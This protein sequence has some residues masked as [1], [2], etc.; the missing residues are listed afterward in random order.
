MKEPNTTTSHQFCETNCIGSVYQKGYNISAAHCSTS[1]STDQRLVTSRTFVQ[2]SSCLTAAQAYVQPSGAIINLQSQDQASLANDHIRFPAHQS[3][4]LFRT[5]SCQPHLLTLLK[6]DLKLI[7]LVCRICSALDCFVK[8]LCFWTFPCLW[9]YINCHSYY[10]YCYQQIPAFLF[11]CVIPNNNIIFFFLLF[12]TVGPTDL[13]NS[14]R[15]SQRIFILVGGNNTILSF[16]PKILL[17]FYYFSRW[18][19]KQSV[20][21]K[22]IRLI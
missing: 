15:Q 21:S 4:T 7:C 5:T 3:G 16:P 8:R 11:Y 20:F 18:R 6:I 12:V 10:Y 9:R 19:G 2:E 13:A 14:Y 17:P 22:S 1:L